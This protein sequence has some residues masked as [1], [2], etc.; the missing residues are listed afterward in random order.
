MESF[1]WADIG[2]KNVN[3]YLLHCKKGG[4]YNS[5][6]CVMATA[7]DVPLSCSY[8]YRAITPPAHERPWTNVSE[9]A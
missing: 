7:L 4:S 6:G 9:L 2:C 1:V 3:G 5:C 8:A